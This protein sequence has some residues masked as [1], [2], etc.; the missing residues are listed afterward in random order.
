MASDNGRVW[1]ADNIL[2]LDGQQYSYFTFKSTYALDNILVSY[3]H[4]VPDE[5]DGSEPMYMFYT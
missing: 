5:P 1:F 2:S 4:C 3:M